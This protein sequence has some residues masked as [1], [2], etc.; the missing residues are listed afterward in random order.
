MTPEEMRGIRD[1]LGL[2][3]EEFGKILEVHNGAISNWEN[4]KF[5]PSKGA[6]MMYKLFQFLIKINKHKQFL[7]W[8]KK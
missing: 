2:S 3:Q 4:A 5:K 1:G 6:A 8:L 7:A